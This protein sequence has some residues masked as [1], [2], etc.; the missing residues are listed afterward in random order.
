MTL[1]TILIVIVWHINEKWH[2][3]IDFTKQNHFPKRNAEMRYKLE[4]VILNK[5]HDFLQSEYKFSPKS[6]DSSTPD[7]TIY[8]TSINQKKTSASLF[9]KYYQRQ[10]FSNKYKNILAF[11]SKNATYSC[12]CEWEKFE[13]MFFSSIKSDIE[14]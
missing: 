6:L 12:R 10:E 11:H 14:E 3:N 1:N 4:K 7:M 13:K 9:E 5:H 8:L 2:H